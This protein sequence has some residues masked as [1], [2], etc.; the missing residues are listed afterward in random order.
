L[1]EREVVLR[2]RERL[3]LKQQE[4]LQGTLGSWRTSKRTFGGSFEKRTSSL[5]R[6]GKLPAS[7]LTPPPPPWTRGWRRAVGTSLG[8]RRRWS[9]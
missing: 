5:G 1:T 7:S 9:R 4:G 3:Q 8:M 6:G 2:R